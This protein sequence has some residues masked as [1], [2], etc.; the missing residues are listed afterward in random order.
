[1][2]SLKGFNLSRQPSTNMESTGAGGANDRGR[3]L[4]GAKHA[5]PRLVM[6]TSASGSQMNAG[7]EAIRFERNASTGYYRLS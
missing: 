4:Q 2:N 6:N 5:E 3:D 1:M 7:A